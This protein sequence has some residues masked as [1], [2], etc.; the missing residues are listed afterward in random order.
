[1]N[2]VE[3]ILQFITHS[4]YWEAKARFELRRHAHDGKGYLCR[5]PQTFTII[6]KKLE[7]K[8]FKLLKIKFTDLERYRKKDTFRD[9]TLWPR[10]QANNPF[11][12][13]KS[14]LFSCGWPAW[15][16][17][18]WYWWS[19]SHLSKGKSLSIP[20]GWHEQGSSKSRAAD[21]NWL[22][23]SRIVHRSR[24]QDM[25]ELHRAHKE[26]LLQRNSLP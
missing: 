20:T 11:K 18:F 4:G 16:S 25:Q 14:A 12:R 23:W 9:L 7:S 3:K 5:D 8:S 26:R 19:Q 15:T 21:H 13:R 24:A 6:W 1:M 17:A 2:C 22:L 10:L